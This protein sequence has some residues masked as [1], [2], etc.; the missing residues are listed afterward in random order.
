MDL[1]I[2]RLFSN[3]EL[4]YSSKGSKLG[5]GSAPVAKS[6]TG[7]F[8]LKAYS[9]DS[10]MLPEDEVLKSC[11]VKARLLSVDKPLFLPVRTLLTVAVTA[12]D[13]IHS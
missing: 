12:Y 11:G 7:V 2:L 3:E 10:T 4:F 9:F 13:V 5:S 6:D 1:A 8:Q